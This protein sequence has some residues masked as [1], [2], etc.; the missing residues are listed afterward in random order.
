MIPFFTCTH[1]LCDIKL[2]APVA[3]WCDHGNQQMMS[4]SLIPCQNTRFPETPHTDILYFLLHKDHNGPINYLSIPRLQFF[5]IKLFLVLKSVFE[6]KLVCAQKFILHQSQKTIL[7]G[8]SGEL[9]WNCPYMDNKI[10]IIII[11]I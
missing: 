10:I 9:T 4:G 7:P 2:A 5:D 8:P 1:P 3:K 6:H 11:A